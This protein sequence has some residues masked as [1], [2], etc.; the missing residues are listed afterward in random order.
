MDFR[1][2]N[3]RNSQMGPDPNGSNNN[4]NAINHRPQQSNFNGLNAIYGTLCKLYPRQNNPPQITAKKKWWL[5]GSD[6]LDFVSVYI[7]KGDPQRNVPSHWHY[8][9]MG[10]SDLY[11]DGRIYPKNNDPSKPSGQGYELT[12][13][14]L[15]D[16]QDVDSFENGISVW[17]DP[18]VWPAAVMQQ[19]AR[20]AF[21]DTRFSVGEAITWHVPLDGSSQSSGVRH[22]LLVDDEQLPPISTQNGYV[23]FIQLY[24]I[25][26]EEVTAVQRW[27]G[28]EIARLLKSHYQTGGPYLITNM[29][30]RASIFDII[31]DARQIVNSGINRDGSNLTGVHVNWCYWNEWNHS[32]AFSRASQ[33]LKDQNGSQ[34]GVSLPGVEIFLTPEAALSLPMMVTGRLNHGYLFS[35]VKSTNPRQII[36]FLSPNNCNNVQANAYTPYVALAIYVQPIFSYNN[37]LQL[38]MTIKVKITDYLKRGFLLQVYVS[39]ELQQAMKIAFRE[40]EVSGSTWTLPLPREYAFTD[41]NMRIVVTANL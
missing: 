39:I 22:L 35:F 27:N 21:N 34:S 15:R 8:V 2:P 11:G 28:R 16:D 26:I 12:F 33:T 40:L 31:P 25:F 30:R 20:W 18:P 37:V 29:N 24:G 41:F 7:N 4:S 3:C 32:G 5:G 13:R 23:Q 9:S 1:Y 36:S 38:F 6:P 19:M 14:L 17:S 10:F